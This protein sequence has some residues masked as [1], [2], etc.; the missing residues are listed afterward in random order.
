[1]TRTQIAILVGILALTLAG[2]ASLFAETRGWADEDRPAALA[3]PAALETPLSLAPEIAPIATPETAETIAAE[4]VEPAAAEVAEPIDPAVE[5]APVT[6][7]QAESAKWKLAYRNDFTD[8]KDVNAFES[9]AKVN[10]ESGGKG[11]AKDLQKPTVKS[12]VVVVDDSDASDGHALAIYTRKAKFATPG[13]EREGW[14]NGRMMITGQNQSPPVRVK[15]RLRM[16]PSVGTK[17]AVMWWPVGGG[18]PWEVDFAETFGG[19]SLNDYW[20]SRQHVRQNWHADINGDGRAKEQLTHADD[21][22]L[23]KYTEFDLYILPDH[24]WVEINGR[25]TFE[26]KDKRY[27]PNGPGFFSIGKALTDGRELRSRTDDT[28]FLDW[29]EIYLPSS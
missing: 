8:L 27:I 17:S 12:N 14:A 28:V 5:S 16:T 7:A 24:V 4:A 2:L 21:V 9:P 3:S 23:T 29:V 13:G 1:M 26:T 11:S 15:V 10:T 20:G 19:K 25:K 18:W 6:I 22:D